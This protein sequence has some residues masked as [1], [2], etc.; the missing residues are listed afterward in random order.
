VSDLHRVLLAN[1]EGR[2]LVAAPFAHFDLE[3]A[4]SLCQLYTLLGATPPPSPTT[5]V[6]A[7]VACGWTQATLDHLPAALALPFREIL[8]LVQK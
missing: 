3:P 7:L 5:V 1:L 6:L 4:A 2:A 8:L